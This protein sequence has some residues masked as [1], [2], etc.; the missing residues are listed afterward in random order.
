M[1]VLKVAKRTIGDFEIV[2]TLTRSD[3]YIVSIMDDYC[4]FIGERIELFFD[5]KIDAL[6]AF[7]NALMVIESTKSAN[8]SDSPIYDIIKT[9]R[10]W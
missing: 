4:G 9:V 8:S 2:V 1:E 10:E 6:V 3:G 5:N 7:D